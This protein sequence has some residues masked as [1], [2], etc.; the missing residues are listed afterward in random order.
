MKCLHKRM[1][2]TEKKSTAEVVV[3]CKYV[4]PNRTQRSN[5]G[6]TPGKHRPKRGGVNCKSRDESSGRWRIF[7]M[8]LEEDDRHIYVEHNDK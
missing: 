4:K 3:R 7:G 6:S 5:L 8:D 1:S 2:R